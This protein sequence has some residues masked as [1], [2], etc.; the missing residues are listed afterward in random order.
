MHGLQFS[1]S[2]LPWHYSGFVVEVRGKLPD[3][4]LCL[5]ASG[6]AQ[7]VDIMLNRN[8]EETELVKLKAQ[9]SHYKAGLSPFDQPY[10]NL[11][12]Q[13]IHMKAWWEALYADPAAR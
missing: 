9:L 2:P 10:D 7:A 3:H 5:H 4:G 6:L 12:P 1:V 13:T 11:G 8:H